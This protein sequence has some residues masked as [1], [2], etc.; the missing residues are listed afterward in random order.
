M[1]EKAVEEKTNAFVA[2]CALQYKD[3]NI[4]SRLVFNVWNISAGSTND[5][6]PRQDLLGKGEM[7]MF[8]KKGRLKT[9]A[10]VISL[11]TGGKKVDDGLDHT[12]RDFQELKRAM[13]KQIR[14]EMPQVPWLDAL[15]IPVAKEKL[16]QYVDDM[17]L[18]EI[19][20]HS[21]SSLVILKITLPSFDHTVL[22][23]DL[24]VAGISLEMQQH[25]S[26]TANVLA[27]SLVQMSIST[28]PS[29]MN[30][31]SIV[32]FSDPEVGRDSPAE[33]M[34]QKLSRSAGRGQEDPKLR[35]NT[36][37]R[38]YLDK[39]LKFPPSRLLK[40]DEKE[41][42]W[43]FRHALTNDGKALTKFLR[44]VDWADA[45]EAV[46]AT[47][48]MG[49]WAPIGTADALELLS[50]N[51]VIKSVRSHAVAALSS[52]ENAELL[53]FLLQLVQALRYEEEDK[54]EL[55]HF[56]LE[57]SLK[58]V[59]VASSLFWYL[60]SELEDPSF[61]TRA[62]NLQTSL[63]AALSSGST[64]NESAVPKSCIPLQLNLMAR[65]RHLFES[66]RNL[67]SAYSK[68]DAIRKMI[69]RNGSCE[70]LLSFECPCPLDPSLI[71]K[72]VV[73]EGCMVFKS[74]VNPVKLTW[75]KKALSD[76]VTQDTISFIYKKGD[77][78]RQDQLVL[79]IFSLMD[80]LLKREHVDLSITPYKVLPT[81]MEDGLIEFV[82]NAVPLSII[83]REYGSVQNFL[84]H[85][86]PSSK[87]HSGIRQN[88]MNKY[89]R[90]CAGYIVFTHLLGI[91]D[92]HNDNV[93]ITTEG[94]LFHIDFGYILGRDPKF[95]NAPLVIPRAIIDG[96]GGP[97]SR[98]YRQFVQLCCE[99]LNILRKSAN[100]LLSL[101]YLMAGS[102]I[103]DIRSDPEMAM[104]KVQEKL[105]LDLSDE[106]MASTFEGALTSAQTA[107]LPRIAEV[108]HRVA[109]GWR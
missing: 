13:K 78:L 91:G 97:E 100:L 72:G 2:V 43:R 23:S 54:S 99:A 73:P 81:S 29:V 62:Q 24:D 65:L 17:Y 59:K 79:Q 49:K 40:R 16:Q 22:Y 3:L 108:Q 85:H 84:S 45:V 109:Q 47:S 86:A 50:P 92:R 93:M 104:L 69:G 11:L 67:R 12:S 7:K 94:K 105:R 68:T 63:L 60:C 89:V 87:S 96:M 15:A 30:E 27:H 33:D 107:V 102:S 32:L 74:K 5:A 48:L 6:K 26:D 14:G 34:A 101:I 66:V 88:T 19:T 1:A 42:L 21:R 57:R 61:G 82:P 52:T 46:Q 41:L 37:E 95:S 44:S 39:I 98:E 80:R 75:N 70:D 55:S 10:H 71:L 64:G 106:D 58:S 103:P 77:D 83:L 53:L 51:F 28:E 8:S 9:G 35:P 4:S 56:L 36:T 18:N 38:E 76:E 20:K 25:F 31:K 90:S